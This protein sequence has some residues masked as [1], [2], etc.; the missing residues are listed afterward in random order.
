MAGLVYIARVNDQLSAVIMSDS[1]F[2]SAV[3]E[4]G[5]TLAVVSGVLIWRYGSENGASEFF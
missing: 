2:F 5:P 1:F 3:E 4:L